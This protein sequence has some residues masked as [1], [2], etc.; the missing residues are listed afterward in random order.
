MPV[1]FCRIATIKQSPSYSLP[2]AQSPAHSVCECRIVWVLESRIVCPCSARRTPENKARLG[3]GRDIT[4]V[5][6]KT[7]VTGNFPG[8]TRR[9]RRRPAAWAAQRKSEFLLKEER[10]KVFSMH[11]LW[12]LA[13]TFYTVESIRGRR[14][15]LFISLFQLLFFAHFYFLSVRLSRKREPDY[16]RRSPAIHKPNIQFYPF[17]SKGTGVTGE[18]SALPQLLPL[19]PVGKS[20]S[21]DI[22]AFRK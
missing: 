15:H 22:N 11:R 12:S 4:A 8:F 19:P 17:A 10:K 2:L 7:R 5:A 6:E 16:E 14:C 21:S 18:P 3:G 9:R 20:D 1:T 13:E